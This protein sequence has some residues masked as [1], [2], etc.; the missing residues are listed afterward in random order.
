MIAPRIAVLKNHNFLFSQ[1]FF[2]NLVILTAVNQNDTSSINRNVSRYLLC[3][4][5][6]FEV[7]RPVSLQDIAV[8]SWRCVA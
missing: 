4:R 6:E 1:H 3:L 2:T 8:Q 7:N 5:S